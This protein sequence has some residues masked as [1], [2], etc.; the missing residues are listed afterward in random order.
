M[1]GKIPS[2]QTDATV[3]E[4]AIRR[5]AR[6]IIG[7][8][9]RS[10]GSRFGAP[11]APAPLS[12]HRAPFFGI[13]TTIGTPADQAKFI[14]LDEYLTG[15]PRIESET[16]QTSAK[17]AAVNVVAGQI[18]GSPLDQS[19]PPGATKE[20]RDGSSSGDHSGNRS[21][22]SN[23]LCRGRDG[24]RERCILPA[25]SS[26]V[27][28]ASPLEILSRVPTLGS[29]RCVSCRHASRRVSHREGLVFMGRPLQL[30]R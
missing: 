19:R 13:S 1:A 23:R 24:S 2:P 28:I 14:V 6:Q 29:Y 27:V 8:S 16:T 4:P 25:R 9:S 18:A 20:R 22:R 21:D 17:P 3:A 5:T 12:F 11:A 26:V 30:S 15:G 10:N 7:H